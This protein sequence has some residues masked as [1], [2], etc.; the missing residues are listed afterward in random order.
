[1]LHTP[2]TAA[3]NALAIWT[4]YD[5]SISKCRTNSWAVASLL[6]GCVLG[7]DPSPSVAPMPA[8]DVL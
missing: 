5:P 1:V 8:I 2:V 6:L 3:P 4:A 7:T